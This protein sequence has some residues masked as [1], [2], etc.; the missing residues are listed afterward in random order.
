MEIESLDF[1]DAVRFLAEKAQIPLPEI[2]YDDEKIK[3]EKRVKQRVLDL[4]KDTALFYVSN[5]KSSRGS[6]HVDYAFKR[7]L[8]SETITKFGIGASLDF[9]SLPKYLKEKGYTEKEMV[10]SGAVGEKDGRCFDW[11]GKR[12]VIPLIDQFNNV[13]SFAGRRIDGGKEQ[14]YIN[15]KETAVFSKGKTFF[16][17]NNLKKLKNII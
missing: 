12:L 3:E 15:T 14:K 7:K 1:N 4:L 2:R 5:L 17:L 8:S 13:I 10:L 6:E 9:N 16:N 11:L